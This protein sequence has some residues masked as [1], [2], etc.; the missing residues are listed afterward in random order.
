MNAGDKAAQHL[1][2]AWNAVYGRQPDPGKGYGDAIKAME[3]ATIPVVCPGNPRAKLG[4]VINDLWGKP[5]KWAVNLKHPA[6]DRQ[7]EIFADML[8]L[9]WNGRPKRPYIWR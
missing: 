1:T 6:P 7:V 4:R 2:L 3:V 8:D 5:S 9:F